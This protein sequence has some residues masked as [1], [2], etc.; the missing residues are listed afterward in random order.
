MAY[1]LGIL[2]VLGIVFYVGSDLVSDKINL[3]SNL[4]PAKFFSQ[5]L[6]PKSEEETILENLQTNIAEVEKFISSATVKDLF[7]SNTLSPDEKNS[8]T[9]ALDAF[10]QGKENIEKLGKIAETEKSLSEEIVSKFLKL[11]IPSSSDLTPTYLPPACQ[12]VCKK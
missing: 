3:I 5:A 4:N 10:Y 11:G 2:V 6:F 8:L 1:I 12:V 9:K 7:R